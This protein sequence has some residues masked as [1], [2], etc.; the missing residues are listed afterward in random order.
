MYAAVLGK[1]AF[2]AFLAIRLV[3]IRQFMIFQ[4]FPKLLAFPIS[5]SKNFK[6][7]RM[8]GRA[9]KWRECIFSRDETREI[10]A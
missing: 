5:P 3:P 10:P 1:T 2:V 9:F 8:Y 6:W 7:K 4:D